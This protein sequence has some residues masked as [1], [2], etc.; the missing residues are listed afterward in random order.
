M[1]VTRVYDSDNLKKLQGNG[2][3]DTEA[4]EVYAMMKGEKEQKAATAEKATE[5]LFN[6]DWRK[7]SLEEVKELVAQ[8]ADVKVKNKWGKTPL[9]LATREGQTDVVKLLLAHGVDVNAADNDGWTS[10]HEASLNGYTGL[11]E[12][13]VSHGADMKAKDKYGNTPVDI[14]SK[15]D[16]PEMATFLQKMAEL[17]A[18][19]RATAKE[20]R[21]VDADIVG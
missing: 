11:E 5:K 16:H 19:R 21:S 9:H 8:G 14:L 3:S 4:C 15:N 17:S 2:A 7:V 10:L 20:I 12:V 13:L 6:L 18:K 1:D